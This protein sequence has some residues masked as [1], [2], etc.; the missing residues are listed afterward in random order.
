MRK[1]GFFPG[2]VLGL[3]FT[4]ALTLGLMTVPASAKDYVKENLERK[5]SYAVKDFGLEL[6]GQVSGY[7]LN[8]TSAPSGHALYVIQAHTTKTYG[9]KVF[10][11]LYYKGWDNKLYYTEKL[12]FTDAV[13]KFLDC[14]DALQAGQTNMIS[15]LCPE[16]GPRRFW[17]STST[18]TAAKSPWP[19]TPSP[20][21]RSAAPSEGSAA[22]SPATASGSSA[23]STSPMSPISMTWMPTPPT[24]APSGTP[25]P[26]PERR[27]H[28]RPLHLRP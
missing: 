24:P 1:R 7:K 17:G 6:G 23:D 19:S 10:F 16:T 5:A 28:H 21:P 11:S 20:S 14:G 22:T 4:L 8:V 3:V 12:N 26:P 15:S 25:P 13:K 27:A 9:D 2:R 18:K